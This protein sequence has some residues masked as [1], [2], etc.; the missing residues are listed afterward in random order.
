MN[1]TL[2]LTESQAACL[3]AL[4]LRKETKSQIAIEAKLDLIKAV[5]ALK[6]LEDVGLSK[7]GEMNR[8]FITRRGRTCRFKTM[9][10]RIRRGNILPGPG[11]RRLL[12]V[13]DGPMRGGE[14]ADLPLDRF[15]SA[16][17]G[18]IHLRKPER[19]FK[20][21][22]V[23]IVESGQNQLAAQVDDARCLVR[24]IHV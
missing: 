14:L 23:G 16:N 1:Q 12:E 11:A 24:R 2:I 18:Q 13:L 22:N 19:S 15:K 4:R 20:K 3:A 9:P 17:S 8:W 21:M 6:R 5:K 7:R 10:D